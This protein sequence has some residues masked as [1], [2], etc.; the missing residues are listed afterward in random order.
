MVTPDTPPVPHVGGPIAGPGAS[1]VLVGGLPAAAV[2]DQCTCI[3]SSDTI[4]TGSANVLIG[5]RPAA[6]AG[7]ACA[8]GGT[9]T[10][11]LPTVLIGG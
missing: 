7:D 9:I 10:H 2:G 1:N 8:H 11:G 3:G 5:G 4:V 6:R